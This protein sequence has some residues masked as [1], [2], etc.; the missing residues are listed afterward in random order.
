MVRRLLLLSGLLLVSG[1]AWPVRQTTDHVVCDL[2]NHPFDI[3][4]EGATEAAKPAETPKGDGGV[5]EHPVGPE[6]HSGARSPHRRA[7]QRLAGVAAGTG[8]AAHA[9]EG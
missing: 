4:P 8:P 2:V 7:D 1:C 3:A 6:E 9:P 5:L